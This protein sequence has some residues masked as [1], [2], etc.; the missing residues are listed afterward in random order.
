MF[1]VSVKY[2]SGSS[3]KVIQPVETESLHEAERHAVTMVNRLFPDY[4]VIVVA[5]GDMQY[6]AYVVYDPVATIQIDLG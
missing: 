6:E 2:G 5:I 3:C 1:T 4:K